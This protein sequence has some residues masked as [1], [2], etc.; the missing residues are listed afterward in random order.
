MQVYL[1][2]HVADMEA[3]K[4]KYRMAMYDRGSGLSIDFP[5]RTA[6]DI[7][8]LFWIITRSVQRIRF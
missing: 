5:G 8:V 4:M 1:Y 6:I 2:K 7:S 3:S